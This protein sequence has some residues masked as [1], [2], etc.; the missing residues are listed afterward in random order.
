MRRSLLA[1]ALPSRGLVPCFAFGLLV[2]VTAGP[3]AAQVGNCAASPSTLCL[4]DDRFQVE[5]TWSDFSGNPLGRP[6][7]PDGGKGRAVELGQ[8]L[9]NQ[10]GGFFWFVDPQD[11]EL[12]IRIFDGRQINGS[13]WVFYGALTNVELELTVTDTVTR[14]KQEYRNPA[15]SFSAVFDTSAFSTG[16]EPRS[17][18]VGGAPSRPV[19]AAV[20]PSSH[21]PSCA[22]PGVACVQDGRFAIQV[23]RE[24]PG[25]APTVIAETATSALVGVVATG[26]PEVG[27]KVVDAREIDGEFWLFATSTPVDRLI[28]RVVDLETGE[29]V[30]YETRDGESITVATRMPFAPAPPGDEWLTTP[31]LP[32]FRFQVRV[33]AGGREIATRR[34]ADCVPETLCVSAAVPGRSELFLRKVGPKPNG[35]LHINVVKFSTSRIEVWVEQTATGQVNYYDLPALEPGGSDLTGFVDRRAFTPTP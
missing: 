18:A 32:G 5:V 12:L 22:D 10:D 4:L 11:I 17:A 25:S 24:V 15:G 30:S 1:T 13:F 8:G 26:G 6:G 19:H 31:E 34:E 20:L 16:P 27:V 33:S 21:L 29:A 2:L 14:R 3:A 35:F 28:L 7:A 9:P 23:V